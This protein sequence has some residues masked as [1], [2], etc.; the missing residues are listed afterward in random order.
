M[1]PSGFNKL[2]TRKVPHIHEKILLYLDYAS[3]KKCHM[4]CK[5]WHKVLTSESVCR[6][7]YSLYGPDMDKEL[8]KHSLA[9]NFERMEN[10]LFKGVNPNGSEEFKRE[11][12]NYLGNTPLIH[13]ASRGQTHLVKLLLNHGADPNKVNKNAP[14]LNA[15]MI[16]V[17]G[18][19]QDMVKL[20]LNEGAS[21]DMFSRSSWGSPLLRAAGQKDSKEMVKMLLKAGAN[22]NATD[23]NGY[24]PLHMAAQSPQED[25]V[26]MLLHSGAAVN[27]ATHNLGVTPLHLAGIYGYTGVVKILLDGGGNPMQIDLNGKTP[28]Q[29]A[30]GA[31]KKDTVKMLQVTGAGN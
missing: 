9:G 1:E 14:H 6:K 31:G 11:R 19:H 25:V 4:V 8:H 27:A 21:P 20:L 13:S 12:D 30:Q 17:Q 29:Y 23:P 2:L 10:L 7:V 26:E 5:T 3:F 28:L 18:K 16:A 24:T 15:L 22:P